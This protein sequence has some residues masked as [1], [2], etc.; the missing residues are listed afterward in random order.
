MIPSALVVVIFKVSCSGPFS[1]THTYFGKYI[2]RSIKVGSLS[3]RLGR[4]ESIRRTQEASIV[5]SSEDVCR[6][7]N[8]AAFV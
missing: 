3:F 7:S 8:N 4:N 1:L 5:S 2:G 6:P